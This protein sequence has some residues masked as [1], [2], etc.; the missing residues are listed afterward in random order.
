MFGHRAYRSWRGTQ[1]QIV[2]DYPDPDALTNSVLDCLEHRHREKEQPEQAGGGVTED[3]TN[4][5]LTGRSRKNVER[6]RAGRATTQLTVGASRRRFW[7]ESVGNSRRY[8][9]RATAHA[10]VAESAKSSKHPDARNCWGGRFRRMILGWRACMGSRTWWRG[11]PASRAPLELPAATRYRG[12]V[13]VFKLIDI[14]GSEVACCGVRIRP[15]ATPPDPQGRKRRID[16]VLGCA[17]SA[18][19]NLRAA[20]GASSAL[21]RPRAWTST[22]QLRFGNFQKLA[23]PRFM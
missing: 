21:M 18:H 23:R 1:K 19:R 14:A 15:A 2:E 6:K 16:R 5:V 7:A 4:T 22:A 17:D 12:A 9:C 8:N 13:A 11:G 3:L 10:A 20:T